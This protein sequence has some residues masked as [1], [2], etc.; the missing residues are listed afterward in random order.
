MLEQEQQRREQAV[1]AEQERRLRALQGL[2]EARLK[3]V[4]ELPLDKRLRALLQVHRVL[5]QL[6][7][8]P[9]QAACPSGS[10]RSRSPS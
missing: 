9:E 5:Q 4:L 6:S 10:A 2:V 3:A 1:R 7:L 8:Q